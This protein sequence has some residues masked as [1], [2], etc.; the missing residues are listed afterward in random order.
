LATPFSR[1]LR[2]L[3]KDSFRLTLT[4]LPLGAALLLGWGA[5]FFFSRIALY[6]VTDS[7]RLEVGREAHPVSASASGKVLSS[8]L[9]LG[10]P[11]DRGEVLVELDAEAVERQIEDKQAERSGLAL[12]LEKISN[13]SR[14]QAQALGE[15][16]QAE[17]AALKEAQAE[18]DQAE[19]AAR[20]AEE[21][22]SRVTRIH[23]QGLVSEA[24]RNRARSEAQERRAQAQA[25]SR[26]LTRLQ[27]DR[28]LE[29]S[30]K[31]ALLAELERQA[32]LLQARL[33]SVEAVLSGLTHELEQ[34]RIRAP[35]AGSL[36]EVV[37]L[38]PGT[39]IDKG[40][41]LG[42]VVPPGELRIVAEFAPPEA[43]GRI[44][45][46]QKARLRLE[47]FPWVQYGTVAAS[48]TRVATE[49]LNGRIRVE[50]G[51][52]QSLSFPVS[53]QHGLPGTLEVE[54]ERISPAALVLRAAGKALSRPKPEPT[55]VG[56]AG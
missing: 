18:Y 30:E 33:S 40:Q 23:E 55:A 47:G 20:L 34:H 45:P 12:Q 21:D 43:L 53:L 56:D 41:R 37:P 9:Q 46:Q 29:Q 49:P 38:Q 28:R 35:A 54:V 52:D 5:W 1:S 31:Q 7:A 25:R 24:E 50:L 32:A 10:R 13:E 48:V 39:M 14:A 26:A 51:L 6:A 11:V 16:R 4:A 27:M 8:R 2:S 44:R 22:S 15:A 42:A 3:Q 19:A 17:T 36:G